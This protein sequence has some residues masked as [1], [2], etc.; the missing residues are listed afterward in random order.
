MQTHTEQRKEIAMS[1]V[2]GKAALVVVLALGAGASSAGVTV[3]FV[4]PEKFLDLPV[5]R[6]ER[7]EVLRDL[8]SHFERL[9]SQLPAGQDLTVEITDIDLVGRGY[10]AYSAR[11]M[12]L[13]RNVSEWPSISLRYTVS[14]NG[15]VLSS[16][17]EKLK[18][19]NFSSRR[20]VRPEHGKLR[21][22]IRMIDE[23]FEKTIL[24]RTPG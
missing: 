8:S 10:P 1:S 22:E 15:Q 9:G 24:R 18:D 16:G 13:A 21:Y 20:D 11:E 2:I 12:R 17:A 7:E 19:M 5:D 23:W 3:N 4:A 6:Q 14:A